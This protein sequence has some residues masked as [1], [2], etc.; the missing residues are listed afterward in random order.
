M[1]QTVRATLGL[2]ELVYEGVLTPG[3]RVA[4]IEL[5]E[6]LGV[7]RTPLRIALSTLAH[8]GLLEPLPGGGFVV[9]AFTAAD[10]ADAI[11]LRGVLE[12]AAARLAAERSAG[13]RAVEPLQLLVDRLADAVAEIVRDLDDEAMERYVDLNEQFHRGV[14][15]LAASAPL[16]RA[17]ANVVALPF[18]GPSAFLS[19]QAV[20][21]GSQEILVVAQHQHCSLVAAIRD[22]HGA[23]AEGIAREH[24]HLAQLNLDLV[25]ANRDAL[26]RVRGGRL[27]V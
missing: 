20:L 10:V 22:G 26:A 21:P 14:V 5:A 2:R 17:L 1:S 27:L 9:R 6:R 12:G 8:E 3:A 4:E 16:A 23:R 7:S 18:A 19:S 11:E 25:L 15:E 13:G 24:A